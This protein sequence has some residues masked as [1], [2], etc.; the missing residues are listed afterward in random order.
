MKIILLKDIKKQGKKGDIL[1]VKD[2]YG[3]FLINNNE[4]IMATPQNLSKLNKANLEKKEEE[5]EEIK[6]CSQLKDKLE[7]EIIKFQV[8]TGAQDRIFGSI[9]AKQIC[10]K[11]NELGYIIDKKQ[12]IINNHLDSLGTHEVNIK[13]HK[14]VVATIKIKLVK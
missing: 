9:S 8:K 3:Q 11:L 10:E 4:A 12:I 7:K 6:K 1:N 5:K 13:L 2:G 14:Q